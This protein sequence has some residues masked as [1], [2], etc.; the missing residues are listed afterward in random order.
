MPVSVVLT[1]DTSINNTS[2]C[3]PGISAQVL[4]WGRQT[5]HLHTDRST[6]GCCVVISA[7][8]TKQ[9]KMDQ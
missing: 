7:M 4:Q 9:S 2:P 6:I 5:V 3:I 8:K 1:M